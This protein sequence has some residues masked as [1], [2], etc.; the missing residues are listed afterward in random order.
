MYEYKKCCLTCAEYAY[1][2]N[3]CRCLVLCSDFRAR[4]ISTFFCDEYNI[5]YADYW[6]LYDEL[7][8]EQKKFADSKFGIFA[9]NERLEF[10]I[11]TV[12]NNHKTKENKQ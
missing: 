3:R 1:V 4:K 5:S 6:A 8:S 10:M 9:F 11:K 12:E 7:T 2:D